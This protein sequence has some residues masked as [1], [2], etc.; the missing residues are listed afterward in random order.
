MLKL[1]LSVYNIKIPSECLEPNMQLETVLRDPKCDL[2]IYRTCD[3]NV[4]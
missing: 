1:D 3:L 2:R 4:F